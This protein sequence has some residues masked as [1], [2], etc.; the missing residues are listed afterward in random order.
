MYVNAF[1]VEV[2]NGDEQLNELIFS[3]RRVSDSTE[4]ELDNA[5]KQLENINKKYSPPLWVSILKY[6]SLFAAFCIT[7]GILNADVGLKQAYK[8]AASLFYIDG[9][10]WIIAVVCIVFGYKIRRNI[11]KD[12]SVSDT[13]KNYENTSQI[14]RQELGIPENADEIDILCEKYKIKNGKV[15]HI[16][17]PMFSHFNVSRFIYIQNGL[18]CLASVNSVIEFPLSSIVNVTNEN[19][20][21]SFTEWNKEIP[22]DDKSLKKYKIVYNNQGIYFTKYYKVTVNDTSGEFYFLIPNYD[23]E[24][25]CGITNT[26]FDEN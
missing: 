15:V 5:F 14:A 2:N 4:K 19:K 22:P 3:S 26:H 20:K 18:L 21:A 6:I 16:D 24:L 13:V 7:V 10:S 8:N 25:F 9:I 12:E 1:G 11:E 17:F 23:I